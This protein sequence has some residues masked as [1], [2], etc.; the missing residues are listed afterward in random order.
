MKRKANFIL[1]LPSLIL[2]TAF[3]LTSA[4]TNEAPR[5]SR[6]L[7]SDPNYFPIAVWLQD[8][9]QAMRYKSAGINV[10]VGLW[11]GPTEQQLAQLKSAGMRLFCSQNRV[12]LTHLDDPTIA[13]W[14]QE[15]EP[16]NAQEVRD[17]VT[18]KRHYGAPVK[19]SKVV[20]I[21]QKMHQLDPTRPVMLNLGQWVANRDWNGRGS[22]GKPSDYLTYVQGGDILSFDVYP[23]ASYEKPN[24]Q[25]YL[26][27]V[28]KGVDQLR[29]WGGPD[30][31]VWNALECTHIGNADRQANPVQ[32][33][34]EVWMSIIHGSRGIIWF[35]HQFKPKF[36]E[37]A[38]LDDPKMLAAVSAINAQIHQLA[39]AINSKEP[40]DVKVV[41]S[42]TEVPIDILA[43][44]SQGA[45]Y[46][47][48]VAMR[49]AASTGAFTL[50]GKSAHQAEVLGE[51]RRVEVKDGRLTDSFAPFAVHLYKID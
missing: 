44:K 38:L 45:T 48:A 26:W 21:Y 15:D 22:E 35:V 34:T 12:A 47:F 51:N 4:Q 7:S 36:D 27:L 3:S 8:P 11:R 5:F 43:R 2:L 10:Y 41:S 18:G 13:G 17:P 46:V 50:G 40:A 32:V 30:K 16:D 39:P 25:D 20:E 49:N 37:H 33:R 19:P 14:M 24:Y 23:I 6:G 31:T 9:S 1:I 42:N 29:E 28:A